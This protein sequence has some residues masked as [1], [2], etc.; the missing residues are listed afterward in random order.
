MLLV[1]FFPFNENHWLFNKKN[2]LRKLL[3]EMNY[4]E[5]DLEFSCFRDVV[6]TCSY[7]H[8]HAIWGSSTP[9]QRAPPPTSLVAAWALAL[10]SDLSRGAMWSF[11]N[12]SLKGV[13]WAL[14][15][16]IFCPLPELGYDGWYSKSEGQGYVTENEYLRKKQ[17]TSLAKTWKYFAK[18]TK[19]HRGCKITPK[20]TRIA[21][22]LKS[23]QLGILM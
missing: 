9:G 16:P 14:A 7:L 15:L 18:Q 8:H 6:E 23:Q 19:I 21:N 11:Q 17:Q 3:N 22:T 1:H 13:E 12:I 5:N 4:K 20:G 2:S 10:G